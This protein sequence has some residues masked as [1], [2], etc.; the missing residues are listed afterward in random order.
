VGLATFGRWCWWPISR[1]AKRA[2]QSRVM[3]CV[4][5]P[6]FARV[7]PF[8]QPP[9]PPIKRDCLRRG[10]RGDFTGFGCRVGSLWATRWAAIPTSYTN[11]T[12]VCQGRWRLRGGRL[13]PSIS[14]VLPRWYGRAP[15]FGR[16]R[17]AQFYMGSVA[18][19]WPA[20]H[21][22]WPVRRGVVA[23]GSGRCPPAWGWQR[24]GGVVGGLLVGGRS[25]RGN[26][27]LCRA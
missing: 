23:I 4:V 16:T 6:L 10:N 3:S 17:A 2:W 19:T 8:H 20:F 11:R 9:N 13:V 22:G 14:V 24:W 12:V 18:G 5:G 7:C 26:H 1:R 25:G 27:V 15:S 21:G